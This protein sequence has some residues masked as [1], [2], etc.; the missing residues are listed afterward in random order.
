MKQKNKICQRPSKLIFFTW[1][2][3]FILFVLQILNF[4]HYATWGEKLNILENEK[5]IIEVENERLKKEIAQI[6][7]LSFVKEKAQ[8]AAFINASTYLYL[9]PQVPVALK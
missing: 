2:L 3:I 9:T 7:S 4:N 1:I 8:K 6:G 5:R